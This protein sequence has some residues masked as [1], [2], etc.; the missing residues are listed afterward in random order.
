[1]T[2]DQLKREAESPRWG[3]GSHNTVRAGEWQEQEEK[4]PDTSGFSEGGEPGVS[5]SPADPIPQE[6]AR[7]TG[8]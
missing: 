4:D 2:S 7:S 6:G 5:L 1:M 3:P 8:Q